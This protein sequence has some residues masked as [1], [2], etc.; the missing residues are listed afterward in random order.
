MERKSVLKI[1]NSV[2]ACPTCG[3]K[4][5]KK[6]KTSTF[7]AFYTHWVEDWECP[8]GHKFLRTYDNETAKAKIEKKK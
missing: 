4:E 8:S 2:P 7:T 3:Q 1:M 6:D 5:C